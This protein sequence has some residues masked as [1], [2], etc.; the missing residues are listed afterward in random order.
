MSTRAIDLT[1]QTFG[2]WTVER[3]ASNDKNG[4]ARWWARCGCGLLQVVLGNNLKA[5][6]TTKCQ[7]CRARPER[8]H[9]E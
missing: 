1:G 8:L 2:H 7:L 5:G 9:A 3:R 4:N 6:A